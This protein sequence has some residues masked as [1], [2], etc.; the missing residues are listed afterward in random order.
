MTVHGTRI[1]I[2]NYCTVHAQA[3]DSDEEVMPCK[4]FSPSSSSSLLLSSSFSS[5]SK[6]DEA[7][8]KYQPPLFDSHQPQLSVAYKLQ[9]GLNSILDRSKASMGTYNE[10]RTFVTNAE[11]ASF[12]RKAICIE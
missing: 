7:L 1:E 6:V 10:T 3:W 2:H 4:W 12:A 8:P 11:S 9:V 5:S